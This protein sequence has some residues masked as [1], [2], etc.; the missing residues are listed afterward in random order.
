MGWV[1]DGLDLC[2]GLLYEHRFA[3]L[4]K[5]LVVV[6][7]SSKRTV[8]SINADFM[9]LRHNLIVGGGVVEFLHSCSMSSRPG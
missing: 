3:M 1:W 4:I 2:A 5:L 6:P 7:L 9:V 8:H